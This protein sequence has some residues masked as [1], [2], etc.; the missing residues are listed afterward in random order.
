MIIQ[1]FVPLFMATVTTLLI[2]PLAIRAARL[3]NLIDL[4]N[5]A[6]HKVHQH[7]V[8]KV[9][10][11]TIGVALFI[12]VLGSG[13]FLVADIRAILLAS[14]VII[15]FGFIDDIKGLSAGWKLLG[16]LIAAVL[17]IQL[18]I[19]I[20]MF[21]NQIL[22]ISITLFW[23]I[24]IT[25][26][27]NLV[28]SMDSLAVGLAA[29]AGAFFMIVTVDAGQLDLT[30]MSAIL[31]GCC[32]G[33]FYFNVIP[34]QTFLGDSGSQFLGFMLAALSIAYTPPNLPQT[35]SWFVPILLLSV[36]IF[37]TTFVV[38][39][40]LQR[41][42][43]IY[44]AGQDHTYHQLIRLGM[45]PIRAVTTMHIGAILASCLAFIA[46]PLPP[47]WANVLFIMALLC[48]LILLFW[49]QKISGRE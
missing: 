8:P 2:T 21:T 22:N 31:L 20:R 11:L 16:Q 27:F 12:L 24:G 38:L 33:V 43:P 1:Y 47:F 17:L 40:R 7:P 49:L 46:L 35:S 28:D 26:A 25:N 14:I 36:P 29:I 10:G 48:G 4:P 23:I 9:G 19:H 30:Y 39:S 18:D 44:Q 37:D 42:L 5:S 45:S 34:A 15:I 6:P 41:R 3:L 32:I 13:R